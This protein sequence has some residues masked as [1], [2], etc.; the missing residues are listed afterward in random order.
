MGVESLCGVLGTYSQVFLA[1]LFYFSK[2][3]LYLFLFI[4]QIN[5]QIL[6]KFRFIFLSTEVCRK[7]FDNFFTS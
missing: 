7:K 3:F 2:Y 5:Y 6:L 1:P 4:G